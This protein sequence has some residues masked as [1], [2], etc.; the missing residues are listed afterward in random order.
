MLRTSPASWTRAAFGVLVLASAGALTLA[1]VSEPPE[2]PQEKEAPAP[3]RTDAGVW[4]GTW[5]Y[6]SRDSRL[7][8]WLRTTAGKPELRLQYQSLAQAEAFETDWNGVATYYLAGQPA[9]FQIE[10]TRRDANTI[11]GKWNW[12]LDFEDSG[13]YEDGAF[14]L[15]RAGDGRQ[16]VL[17]FDK[18][19]RRIRRNADVTRY[20]I[21]TAWTFTKASK[22]LVLWDEVY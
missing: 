1:S 14:T 3:P 20:T 18:L 19:E 8:L 5:V 21:K 16:L 12:D 17:R 11:E 6:V 9:S 22:R 10:I 7:A 4:D 15:Y 2:A 13:R